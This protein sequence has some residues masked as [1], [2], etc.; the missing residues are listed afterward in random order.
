MIPTELL[1]LAS[2]LWQSTLFATAAWL[3]TLAVRRNR[4][5]VRYSIWMAAPVKFLIPFSLLISMGSHVEWRTAPPNAQPQG[6][7]L[8]N[9]L[10][11]FAQLP[12]D[13]SIF[14]AL[15]EQLG[16]QL[17]PAKGRVEVLVIDHV[18]RPT[19]N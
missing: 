1:P 8:L 7:D 10:G 13:P 4:A 15:Q 14:A 11:P 17:K 19:E 16:L 3:L 6:A 9:D 12:G 5:A 2:H 18:E